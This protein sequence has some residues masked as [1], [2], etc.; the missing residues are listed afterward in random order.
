M[1]ET[2]TTET[3]SADDVAFRDTISDEPGYAHLLREKDSLEA[4]EE[5]VSE[6]I[7]QT[8][9]DQDEE[10]AGYLAKLVDR[11]HEAEDADVVTLLEEA[12]LPE[13]MKTLLGRFFAN[14]RRQLEIDEELEAYAPELAANLVARITEFEARIDP[15]AV[16]EI[17]IEEQHTPEGVNI[18]AVRQTEAALG[19]SIAIRRYL[20]SL[21]PDE[22]PNFYSLRVL[23]ATLSDRVAKFEERGLLLPAVPTPERQEEQD[24]PEA[25]FAET[26]ATFERI[27]LLTRAYRKTYGTEQLKQ[28]RDI[29]TLLDIDDRPAESLDSA[30]TSL[31]YDKPPAVRRALAQHGM[32]VFESIPEHDRV[33]DMDTKAYRTFVEN[34]REIDPQRALETIEITGDFKELP[35]DF[36]E[37]QLREF[38]EQNLPPLA[39]H[40]VSRVEFRALEEDEQDDTTLGY[41]WRDPETGTSTI[42]ISA[43]ALR[44]MWREQILDQVGKIAPDKALQIA[45]DE[46]KAKM[47][48]TIEHE[49]MHALH[50]DLPLAFLDHWHQITEEDQTPVS[51]YVLNTRRTRPFHGDREDF[52]VSGEVFRG[53]PERL[54]A[55][56]ARRYRALQNLHADIMPTYDATLRARQDALIRAFPE[57]L[58]RIGETPEVYRKSEIAIIHKVSDA[59]VEAE[60][61][62]RERPS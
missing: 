49:F 53:R 51:A 35:F 20:E 41:H 55:L 25:A 6:E 48:G 22:I 50:I 7:N 28:I 11:V 13:G 43:P 39:Y 24:D 16:A 37:Q 3:P 40:R 38:I 2:E 44:K 17:I 61:R 60:R 27:D 10:R 21:G 15:Q 29:H 33:L 9:G 8:W 57:V 5:S 30:A 32:R 62:A 59:S 19:H 18:G 46:V 45:R 1:P 26:L 36:D 14:S 23:D 34:A 58:A 42:V 47:K 31:N 12:D 52:A 56:S 54:A 4:E